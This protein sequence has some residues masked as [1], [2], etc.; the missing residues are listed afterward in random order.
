MPLYS[1]LMAYVASAITAENTGDPGLK[2][3]Q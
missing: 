1:N 2:T 3:F